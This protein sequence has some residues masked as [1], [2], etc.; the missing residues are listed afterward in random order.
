MVAKDIETIVI[1]AK[2]TAVFHSSPLYIPLTMLGNWLSKW[3]GERMFREGSSKGKKKVIVYH[4]IKRITIG[5]TVLEN[6]VLSATPRLVSMIKARATKSI[7]EI[8]P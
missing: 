6:T 3:L 8:N 4:K 7:D 1:E 2:P 5:T